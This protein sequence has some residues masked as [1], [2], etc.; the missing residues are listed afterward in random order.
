MPRVYDGQSSIK[1]FAN[2]PEGTQNTQLNIRPAFSAE[3]MALQDF[4]CPLLFMTH[5]DL[6]GSAHG[7]LSIAMKRAKI[8]LPPLRAQPKTTQSDGTV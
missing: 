8:R 7:A 4:N 1:L 2:P 3:D 5:P 6:F